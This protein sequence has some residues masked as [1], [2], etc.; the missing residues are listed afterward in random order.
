MKGYSS[1]KR[2]L[3][4]LNRH[5]WA[6]LGCF[7]A[8][9]AIAGAFARVQPE[10]QTAFLVQGAV[11][12]Q[13][14]TATNST[15]ETQPSMEQQQVPNPE[16]L[17][18][19]PVIR[20]VTE[21]LKSKKQT[22]EP[23]IL[24]SQVKLKQDSKQAN[25]I[26]IEYQDDDEQRAKLLVES[27]IN[28]LH[29]QSLTAKYKDIEASL[30]VLKDQKRK[31]EEDLQ[32]AEEKLKDFSQQ[33]RPAIQAAIDGSLVS[34]ITTSQQ[35]QRQFRREMAGIDAEISSLQKRLGLTPEQAY[36]AS[37]LSADTTISNLKA[38]LY[39]IESEIANQSQEL[40]PKH[41]DIVVLK[42]QQKTY[43][44]QLQQRVGEVIGGDRNRVSLQTINDLQNGTSLDKA[45]QDLA[46]KLVAL[47]TQRDRLA[48]ELTILD[49]FEPELL[50]TYKDGTALKLE[51]DERTRDVTRYREAFDQLQK[52]LAATEL[53]RAGLRSDWMKD[54]SPQ[55]KAITDWS[56]SEPVILVLGGVLGLLLSAGL[57]LLLD[58]VNGKILVP[59]EVHA[60][61][62]GRMP[63]LGILP[64]LP[65]GRLPIVIE[66]NS[67]HLEF[68]ELVRS[69]LHH[70]SGK[71]A[72]KT[73]VFTSIT[74]KEGKTVSAYN[75]AIASAK[76]GKKTLLI[77]ADL[78]SSSQASVVQVDP[79]QCEK[80]DS[81]IDY[82]N[83]ENIHEVATIQNLHIL[84]SPGPIEQ[85]AEVLES[86][87]FQA[88]LRYSRDTFDFVVIDTSALRYSDALLV[89]PHTDGLVLV[90]RPGY[91]D[92]KNLQVVI[93]KLKEFGDVKLLG[94]VVNGVAMTAEHSQLMFL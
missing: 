15:K 28:A 51:L 68:Y 5:K 7:A 16:S 65:Q 27:L 72:I 35:Q 60:I 67:P 8:T 47:Q 41:P 84:P 57:V 3:A 24:R 79:V 85:A 58:L 71:Q 64:S 19:E 13:I 81:S 87:R 93:E 38:K 18:S 42:H 45:R 90:T 59:E 52:Q 78:R 22:V 82:M 88:L 21:N 75:L 69:S 17:L 33:E 10:P 77:E 55:V 53:R 9:A 94:V 11:V 56:L 66:A 39:E 40:Q 12:Y 32:V 62:Q 4:A 6:G 26:L 48:Q 89:E 23:N 25:K 63:V 86:A 91:T 70:Y 61:A 14:A 2:Y 80:I 46:N 34:A 74:G 30:R 44:N 50:Q 73:I 20:L 92:R 43:E 49:R 37:A 31:L 54:G 29:H 83:A 76:A 36:I 1:F